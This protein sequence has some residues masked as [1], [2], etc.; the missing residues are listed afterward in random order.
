VQSLSTFENLSVFFQY[1]ITYMLQPMNLVIMF[2]SMIIGI[3]FGVLPGLSATIAIALFASITY[4]ASLDMALT[5]LLGVY[6]GAIYGGSI[7]AI[8]INI[9]GTGSAAAT[10]LD[11]HP[12]ALKGEARF[13]NTLARSASLIG[14]MF[15]M[16]VF[17]LFTPL[18]TKLALQFTSPEFFWLA[19]FG[20][21]ICGSISGSDVKV[22]GWISGVIGILMALVGLDDIQGWTRL[23]FGIPDLMSGIPFVPMTIAFFGLPQV[24]RVM[25][26]SKNIVVDKVADGTTRGKL[27]PV[28]K[29]NLI[30]IFKWGF[31]GVGIGAVPGV[32]ENIAAWVAYDDAKRHHPNGKDFGTGI[33]EGVMAPETANNAAIGG[34]IIPLISLG[35]PGSPPAAMLLGALTMH[36]LKVGPL[37]SVEQPLIIPQIGV[38]LVWSTIFLYVCGV[39]IMRPMVSILKISPKVLMPIIAV[40]CVVGT[41]AYNNNPF[42][43]ALVFT[44]A[45]AGYFF[46]KMKYSSAALILGLILGNMADSYFRRALFISDGNVLA[47]V[48]RPISL[49]FFLACIWTILKEFGVIPKQ[50]FKRRKG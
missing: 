20:I 25:K 6:V 16:V 11:G 2:G 29:R 27:V 22:K 33:Y 26:D 12:L 13:A 48:N 30:G 31:I 40:L 49:L 21:L 35:I 10:C 39:L 50:L 17:V 32:G 1:S 37:L 43:L 47:L 5:V 15:G 23:T 41:F 8:L 45:V 14:T 46:D 36:G 28:I 3:I 38:I 42:H 44:C 4:G 7:S 34:A 24:V 18:M 19:I 9:P